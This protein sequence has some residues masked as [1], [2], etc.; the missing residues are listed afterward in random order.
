MFF[1]GTLINTNIPIPLGLDFFRPVQTPVQII[2]K[3]LDVHLLL[4]LGIWRCQKIHLLWITGCYPK[5]L[6]R[7]GQQQIQSNNFTNLGSASIRRHE[8]I[9]KTI[10]MVSRIK[11]C[12]TAIYLVLLTDVTSRVN[13]MKLSFLTRG[14]AKHRSELLRR[15]ALSISRSLTM[16]LAIG[17]SSGP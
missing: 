7:F 4:F 15:G 11:Y 17:M 8:T 16:M 9:D 5:P 1:N 12:T 2:V 13:M 10:K 14:Y 6:A 3:Y